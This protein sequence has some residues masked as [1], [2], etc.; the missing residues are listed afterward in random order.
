MTGASVR[1]L[2][3]PA[4][5]RLLPMQPCVALMRDAFRA[6]AEGRAAQPIRQ[7]MPT[8]N[9]KGVLMTM[10]GALIAPDW[11]GIK[12]ISIFPGNFGGD[13]HTH[14]GMVLLFDAND[15]RPVAILDG[16]EITSIRTAA[17]T[18][19][20]TDAL[21]VLEA[22]SLGVFGYGDQA[23]THLEAIKLVR[24]L[25]QVYVWGR[26]PSKARAFAERH[27]ADLNI[28]AVETPREAAQADILCLTT[29][30][31]EPYFEGDW[32]R[33]GQHVNLVGSGVP[34]TAEVD[35][36]TLARS[37]VYVDFEESARILAGE[38]RRAWDVSAIPEDHVL[39]SIGQ[40]LTGKAVGR[41]SAEDITL[42]KS[43]GMVAEDL[44]AAD[45][46]LRA[47]EAADDG[48][49]ITF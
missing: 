31:S 19:V 27:A 36:A 43:L 46:I 24:D 3:A 18:A 37:R 5:R 14:Q 38:L 1:V 39:G 17:A 47:A 6:E 13:L 15:G 29:A 12:V 40:V 16:G 32:L 4:V 26:D 7:S 30:A 20:A 42:F 33:L 44:V 11:L 34:T 22:S 49:T 45:Y 23:N 8:P 35:A 48:E 41:T 2:N 21:A 9:C 10:P 25:R 28:V